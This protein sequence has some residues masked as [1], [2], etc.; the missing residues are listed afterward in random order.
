MNGIA[1]EKD[2]IFRHQRCTANA[3]LVSLE[4]NAP[5]V[6]RHIVAR[7]LGKPEESL[8]LTDE[9]ARRVFGEGIPLK[10]VFH[11]HSGLFAIICSHGMMTPTGHTIV[12]V[13]EKY[14][15]TEE[16]IVLAKNLVAVYEQFTEMVRGKSP[17]FN[18]ILAPM[19][20]YQTL[21]RGEQDRL[22]NSEESQM[23]QMC[24]MSSNITLNGYF[25]GLESSFGKFF[26]LF[27][28]TWLSVEEFDAYTEALTKALSDFIACLPGED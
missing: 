15:G 12:Q 7:S 28:L 2:E 25:E 18:Q 22:L 17:V 1:E 9:V 5:T 27:A 8:W 14:E 21:G 19:E 26:R 11:D 4:Q 16:Q 10:F 3:C 20:I 6:R 24:G 23:A 13:I